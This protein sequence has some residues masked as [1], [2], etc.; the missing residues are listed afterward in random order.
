MT[1]LYEKNL[2]LELPDESASLTLAIRLAHCFTTPMILAF[3]GEIGTGKTTI[4][5]AVLK[6]LGVQ[7]A[8]KSPTFSLV[9]SYQ[10]QDTV[11][12]HF[13]LYRV[14]DESELDSL[15]FRDYFSP[16]SLCFIEW[17]EHAGVALPNIDIHFKLAIKGAGRSMQ[18][19]ALSAAGEGVLPCLAGES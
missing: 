4:I 9:E 13:D 3:S 8:I 19:H 2:S 6:E 16:N 14:R 1:K 10:V 7:S 17:A 15:G 11:I 12:H 5:R 18:I